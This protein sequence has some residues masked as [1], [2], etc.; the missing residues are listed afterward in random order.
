[1][2][3]DYIDSNKACS[4]K[5]P[6]PKV[7]VKRKNSQYAKMIKKCYCG[8]YSELTLINQYMYQKFIVIPHLKDIFDKISQ[9]ELEHFNILGELLIALGES[10]SFLLEK[11]HKTYNWSTNCISYENN[12]KDI[13][14]KNIQNEEKIIK[15]Y[16]NI[17]KIVEDDNI[18][19][20][21]NRII[22]DEELHL[23]IFK[24]IYKNEIV[25]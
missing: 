22:L 2:K 10:P 20:I 17:A 7:D 13:L 8:L 16:R 18:I 9:V 1:M 19:T 21:L 23:K 25:K 14:I 6:Y 3:R 11:N 15:E 24:E 4:I 5:L 12:L